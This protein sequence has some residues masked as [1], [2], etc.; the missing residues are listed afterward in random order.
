MEENGFDWIGSIGNWKWSFG[1]WIIKFYI[2]LSGKVLRIRFY[3]IGY[4]CI[5][6]YWIISMGL[7]LWS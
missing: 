1:S 5:G 3:I 7:G 4:G 2:Y 6:L